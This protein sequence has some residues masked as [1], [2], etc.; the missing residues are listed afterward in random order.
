MTEGEGYTS[1]LAGDDSQLVA[2]REDAAMS[3]ANHKKGWDEGW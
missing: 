1:G 2:A 3:E